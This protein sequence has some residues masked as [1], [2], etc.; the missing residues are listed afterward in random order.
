ML[1]V[2]SIQWIAGMGN[3]DSLH[4]NSQLILGIIVGDGEMRYIGV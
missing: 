2:H 4:P 1:Q 3:T